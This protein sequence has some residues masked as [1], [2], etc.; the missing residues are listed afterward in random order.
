M[1]FLTKTSSTSDRFIDKGPKIAPAPYKDINT[2]K[3]NTIISTSDT[4]KGKWTLNMTYEKKN[5]Y[6]S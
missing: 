1:N 6:E 5:L 2:T 4:K 3:A